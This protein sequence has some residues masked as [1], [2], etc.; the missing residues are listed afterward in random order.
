MNQNIFKNIGK[1]IESYK[2]SAV[3]KREAFYH[4][5]FYVSLCSIFEKLFEGIYVNLNG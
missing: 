5:A 4:S 2:K 3:S 1:S